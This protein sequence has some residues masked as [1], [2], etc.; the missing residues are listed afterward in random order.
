MYF[1]SK[2]MKPV[3]FTVLV[4]IFIF[5]AG[6][7]CRPRMLLNSEVFQGLTTIQGGIVLFKSVGRRFKT[8]CFCKKFRKVLES[9]RRRELYL[10]VEFGEKLVFR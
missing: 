3:P 5:S 7:L 4:Q 10:E 2:N 9:F 8:D 6:P 1:N